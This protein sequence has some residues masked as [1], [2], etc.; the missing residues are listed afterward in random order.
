MVKHRKMDDQLLTHVE[1][2]R[3]VTPGVR[4]E[5]TYEFIRDASNQVIGYKLRGARFRDVR[6]ER[7]V[8]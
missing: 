5:L 7:H 6:F 8:R 4:G 1:G 2:N 3:F